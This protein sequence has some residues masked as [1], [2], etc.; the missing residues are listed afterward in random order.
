M[1]TPYL[2][3]ADARDLRRSRGVADSLAVLLKYSDVVLHRKLS[4]DSPIARI[5]FDVLE[6]IRCEAL[7]DKRYVGI[8]QNLDVAFGS[9]CLE[10]RRDRV[11]ESAVG[12][13]VYTVTHMAR[14]R[15]VRITID[16]DVDSVIETTRAS[17]GSI[18]GTSLRELRSHVGSQTNYAVHAV[19]IAERIAAFAGPVAKL[20]AADS[21]AGGFYR[22]LVPAE[23]ESSEPEPT[24]FGQRSGG[25]SST[26]FSFEGLAGYHVFTKAFDR[27]I[28][29][30]TLYRDNV[31][32][33]LRS[34][35]DEQ[36]G[37]QSVSVHRL[38]DRMRQLFASPVIDGWNFGE[39]EGVIDA[40]RLSQ[41]IATG[42]SRN[43]FRSN[44][45]VPAADTAIAF[46]IDNSGSMKSQRHRT[47]AVLV[48]TI[49]R[50][51]DLAGVANEILG[52]TTGG[53]S[54]GHAATSWR[55][56]GAPPSPG[57]L[58]HVDHIV[59]KSAD[60]TWRQSRR[61]IAA[62]MRTD[63]FRE[64]VD[65]EALVWA[66]SRMMNRPEP[67]KAIVV[68]SDGAPMDT[69]TVRENGEG[70]L[71]SH[72]SAVADQIERSSPVQLGAIGLDL[73]VSPYYRSTA[74]VD[75]SGTLTLSDYDCLR[76]LLSQ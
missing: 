33:H 49:S 8:R 54:G 43:I 46:L 31:L 36:V 10:A 64:G 60:A 38:A 65:G 13:L 11:D 42:S 72:L 63:H 27:E 66:H 28:D 6:Q 32:Q 73:D 12:L 7:V 29:A 1:S 76:S 14:A 45:I 21:D 40:R 17:I 26:G 67:R 23:W 55:A 4:P 41:L 75:L 61:S 71:T 5:I 57:R 25:A 44:R 52:F 15:L 50:A 70:F 37:A 74:E 34:D 20:Q 69:A 47:V 48:D 30:S 16:E 56:A 24:Q 19:D 39:E 35:L 58:N 51:L 3:A 53:W 62:L 59:Y 9:W 68:I 2:S 18:I 22:L